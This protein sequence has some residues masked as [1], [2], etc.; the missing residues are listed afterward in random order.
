[1]RRGVPLSEMATMAPPGCEGAMLYR[2][3]KASHSA[4]SHCV[5]RVEAGVP[6]PKRPHI[7]LWD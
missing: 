7:L 6:R 4:K 1:M 5:A 2:R 3:L